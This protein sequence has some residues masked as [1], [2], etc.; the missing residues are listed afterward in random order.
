MN[1]SSQRPA[2]NK[3]RRRF[4]ATCTGAG[5]ATFIPGNSGFAARSADTIYD[6]LLKTYVIG[7]SDGVNRVRYSV[8]RKSGHQDLKAYLSELQAMRPSAMSRADAMAFWINLYNAKTLDVILDHYPVK[9]IKDINLGGGFFG[10]GPWKAK[11]V[12]VENRSLSLDNVEHDI[13]RARFGE[14]LV[15]YALNCASIGCPDLLTSVWAA[16]TLQAQF[17]RGARAY[18]NHPRGINIRNNRFTASKIYRW[19]ADDFG[20]ASGLKTHWQNYANPELAAE[21][22]RLASPKSYVYDWSLNDAV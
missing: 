9:S 17:E 21:L 7:G 15:H 3:S 4:I 1:Q 10:G 16:N 8:F 19:Y 13:L 20:G 14:P 22:A 2:F 11:L 12:T 5:L 6:K 18:V